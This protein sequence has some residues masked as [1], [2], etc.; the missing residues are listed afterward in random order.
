MEE[1]EETETAVRCV[2]SSNFEAVGISEKERKALEVVE[3]EE[4]V[5]LS[6]LMKGKY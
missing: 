6:E 2:D 4:Q 1:S 5:V 3:V